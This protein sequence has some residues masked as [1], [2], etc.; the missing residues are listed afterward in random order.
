MGDDRIASSYNE[1]HPF[2]RDMSETHT[3]SDEGLPYSFNF[4]SFY[5]L[6]RRAGRYIY[7]L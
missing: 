6:V 2:Q 7:R 1:I 3:P 4:N 5:F